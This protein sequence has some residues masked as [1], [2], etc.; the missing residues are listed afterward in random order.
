MISSPA[1]SACETLGYSSR[2]R[3]LIANFCGVPTADLRIF[4]LA[5]QHGDEPD[6]RDAAAEFLIRALTGQLQAQ[7]HLAILIDANPDG[8]A[9]R[10]RRNA[11]DIDL[12]RDHLFLSTPETLA[13]HRFI[14]KWKPDLILDVHTYRPWRKE[15]MPY[16]FVFPQEMMID[17]PTNPAVR[18]AVGPA[19]QRNAMNFVATR[20]AEANIRNDRY[21]L[22]RP[23]MVRHSTAE[24]LDARNNL[25]LRFEVP[26]VLL[27]GRRAS[28]D[29]SIEFTPPQTAILRAIQAV[30]DWA[31]ENAREL[32][33]RPPASDKTPI[34]CHYTG[35]A[36]HCY[37]EM[38]SAIKG[39]ISRTRLPGSYL[40]EVTATKTIEMP[41][42]YG[43]P[44]SL[45]GVLDILAKHQFLTGETQSPQ[46]ETYRIESITP[47]IEEDSPPLPLCSRESASV[48]LKDYILYPAQQTGRSL[49]ALLLEP[50]SQYGP[51][52]LPELAAALQPGATYPIV[53][54]AVL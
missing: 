10:T 18:T 13:V 36:A 1:T 35:S 32:R 15:L 24:V 40:P 21:T 46:A 6:A 37:M 16:D 9:A 31:V 49:L 48:N 33:H 20:M 19:L 38:Q 50:E 29:D 17:F 3:P 44:R 28:P 41:A 39:G 7:V 5:G 45:T 34:R 23:D 42:A 27:E 22:I 2:G 14:E 26:V 8:A 54:V 47:A 30:V 43:V 51:H 25:A 12:N 11:Q 52:R 53:R 4:I